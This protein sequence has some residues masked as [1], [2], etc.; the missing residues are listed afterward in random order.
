MTR[1]ERILLILVGAMSLLALGSFVVSALFSEDP[2]LDR[3]AELEQEIEQQERQIRLGAKARR[4]IGEMEKHALPADIQLAQDRYQEWLFER[5]EKAGLRQ[6]SVDPVSGRSASRAGTP[7]AFSIRGVGNLGQFTALLGSFYYVDFLHQIR[8]L[9]VR[10]L[11]GTKDLD[12]S[13]LVQAMSLPGVTERDTLPEIA[14]AR[15]SADNLEQATRD[16]FER[17]L[18]APE[19]NAPRLAK[20]SDIQIELGK[21]V[22]IEPKAEDADELDKLRWSL[23]DGI[24]DGA[25]FETTSGRFRWTPKD[26][27]SYAIELR[28]TDDG[29]P[30]KAATQRV[31]IRVVEPPPP[32]KIVVP[33]EKPKPSFDRAKYAYLISTIQ[34][35]EQWQMWLHD[36]TNDRIE[37]LTLGDR[38][39]VGSVQ[40]TVIR[41][42]ARS[43]ELEADGK[44]LLV[45]LGENLTEASE[46]P[47]GGI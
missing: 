36:R 19:N 30:A 7:I 29:Y 8:Q 32:E 41:I 31:A 9:Q 14:Q 40:A 1:R 13:L 22:A 18:F 34:T 6:W 43:V 27:G 23:V 28:V 16:I 39:D 46:L 2:R 17:N 4:L 15:I 5:L 45:S 3:I 21:S 12:I 37:R 25:N 26:V 35:G 33:S 20:I 42:S 24:P 38:V 10:P 11:E 47:G 44:R